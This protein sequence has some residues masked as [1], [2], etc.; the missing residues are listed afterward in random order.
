MIVI[1]TTF[2]A[3]PNVSKVAKIAFRRGCEWLNYYYI[4]RMRGGDSQINDRKRAT[5]YIFPACAGVILWKAETPE[6]VRDI[7]RMRGGDSNSDE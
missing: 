6:E 4:P 5:R 7:P 1:L 2:G 3:G